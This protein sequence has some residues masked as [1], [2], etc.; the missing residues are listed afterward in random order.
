MHVL[1]EESP[2]TVRE[3]ME[4]L[5]P[6]KKWAYT[7]IKTMLVRL[8]AKGAVSERKRSNLGFFQPTV[9]KRE[10]RAAAL[11]SV[12]DDAFEGA[13][14]PLV[15]FL[16]EEESLSPAERHQLKRML[17]EKPKRGG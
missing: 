8:L 17:E 2:I 6:G 15:H 12:L 7:T 9:T 13:F 1:W 5:G 11:R 16:V 10:A 4:R 14:G 3:M